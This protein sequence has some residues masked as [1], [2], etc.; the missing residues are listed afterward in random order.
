[1]K[2]RFASSGAF[3]AI[4]PS[5]LALGQNQTVSL[6]GG[7][8]QLLLTGR[9]VNGHILLSSNDYWGVI[10]AAQDLA[11]DVGKVVGTNLTLANWLA[12]NSKLSTSPHAATS[13]EDG[14]TTVLYT[15][16]PT[17]NNVNVSAPGSRPLRRS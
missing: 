16:N 10:R 17:T 1:M 12:P 4:L 14:Q 7:P 13:T 6:T 11:E 8:G 5:V 9:G 15:Y 2:F 3:L